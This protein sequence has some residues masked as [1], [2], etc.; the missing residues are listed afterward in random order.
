[1][2]LLL[3]FEPM[4]LEAGS[5]TSVISGMEERWSSEEP[6]IVGKF[7]QFSSAFHLLNGTTD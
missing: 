1:M 5:E 6:R 2:L 4:K 3:F 7:T